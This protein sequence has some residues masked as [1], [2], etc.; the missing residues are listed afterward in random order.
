MMIPEYIKS[1]P[2]YWG[3]TI[4]SAE[5]T[6]TT[7][8]SV[9]DQMINAEWIVKKIEQVRSMTDLQQRQET[10]AA[11]LPYFVL[12]KFKENYRKNEN[13]L[14]ANY[15][16]ADFD[17][18]G[19]D[20]MKR[21]Q[22]KLEQ[23]ERVLAFFRSPSND[24][25]KPIFKLDTII[26]D[27]KFFAS[28]YEDVITTIATEYGVKPDLSCKDPARAIFYSH[29]TE[30]HIKEEG[31][32]RALKVILP[33]GGVLKGRPPKQADSFSTSTALLE[34]FKPAG[35]GE[36]THQMSQLIG[37]C[38]NKGMSADLCLHFVRLWNE[39]NTPPH[40]EKK[41]IS[42]V[43]DM[44]ARYKKVDLPFDI[45]EKDNQY[46]RFSLGD[47][48]KKEKLLT[49]FRIDAKELLVTKASDGDGDVLLVD[50]HS[51][52][53]NKYED[54]VLMVQDWTSEGLHNAIGKMD[55]TVVA[56]D[57]EVKILKMY[58]NSRIPLRKTGTKMVGL[59]E[60]HE[61][62]VTKHCNIDKHGVMEKME[63]VPYDRGGDSFYNKIVYLD[64][65]DDEYLASAKRFYDLI[66][67]IND[68]QAIV[69]MLGWHFMA[70]MRPI[71]MEY[72]RRFP[73]LFIPGSMGSG[74]TSTAQLFMKLFGYK[75]HDIATADMRKFPMLKALA[76]TNGIPV[77][78]DEFKE[79]DMTDFN[80]NDI[81]RYIRKNADGGVESKG[82]ADQT[83]TD[84]GIVAPWVLMGEW[85]IK[86]PAERERMIIPRFSAV[87][88]SDTAMQKAYLELYEN[89]EL[90]G[91]MPRYIT[92]L[93]NQSMKKRYD[94]AFQYAMHHF[95][96][97]GTVPRVLHNLVVMLT[98]INLFADYA[99]FIGLPKPI[100]N[101]PAILNGQ[102]TEITG[103]PTGQVESSFDQLLGE[104]SRM[105][106]REKN[107]ATGMATG[108]SKEPWYTMLTTFTDK[109]TGMTIAPALAIRFSL[110]LPKVKEFA[111]KTSSDIDILDELG[112]RRMM[113]P[114]E[115]KYLIS[116]SSP[117]RVGGKT[118]HCVIL[119]P[120]KARASGIDLEGFEEQ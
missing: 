79:G 91:F 118:Y 48:E 112:Y 16:V 117:A 72:K 34:M 24:G 104:M 8:H 18:L 31:K 59:N 86:N 101:I 43:S 65:T 42:T 73:V 17:H 75:S 13:F 103:T 23:D 81:H 89:T 3:K 95:K 33:K 108:A 4:K 111:K 94:D 74:K 44:Y 88:K 93:L 114:Q 85:S 67:Q 70:P 2:A 36:R 76:S 80:I 116:A 15:I 77:Y 82:H 90:R 60:S 100:I 69:P 25:I 46:Y 63:I 21:I 66:L 71:I 62:W 54:I 28:Y 39:K 12:N 11:L 102:L 113:K 64:Q 1:I 41:L 47:P 99:L 92:W 10:K 29:D 40:A 49:T 30:P 35:P 61:I 51:A 50:V 115:T 107:D 119:D 84:W 120:V 5:V 32:F 78:T 57:P 97:M 53:G 58:V 106:I 55:C 87:V 83:T 52:E 27:A 68:P 96:G 19:P 110:A 22:E 26:T 98:G 7:L 38:I 56:T 9:L 14:E 105:S 37:M 45:I 20:T 6:E 109:S